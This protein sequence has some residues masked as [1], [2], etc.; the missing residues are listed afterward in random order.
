M[1]GFEP[2]AELLEGEIVDGTDLVDE[3][4]FETGQFELP[5]AA[6]HA[7]RVFAEASSSGARSRH[8]GMTHAKASRDFSETALSAQ[9]AIP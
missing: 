8:V 3:H 2:G 7:G 1:L 9:Y 4:L 6:L 5:V